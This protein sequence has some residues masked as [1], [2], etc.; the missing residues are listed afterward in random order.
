MER[1][2][3][4]HFAEQFREKLL[5]I[6]V[7]LVDVDGVLTDGKISYFGSEVGFNRSFHAKDGYGFKM[8]AMAGLKVGFISGGDSIGVKK[9]S[10]YLK[11]DYS[12]L[13]NE[14]KREAYQKVLDDGYSDSEILYIGDEFFDLPLLKRAGFSATVPHSSDEILEAVDYVTQRP[15]GEGAVREVIDMVRHVQN[16]VPDIPDFGE[17]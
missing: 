14:D 9:R 3:Y 11:L 17:K 13:G 7:F 6:K 5:P 8:L 16:I 2:D 4:R 15:A 1:V 10:E 12:F